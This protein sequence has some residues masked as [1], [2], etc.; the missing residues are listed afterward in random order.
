MGIPM[1]CIENVLPF[2]IGLSLSGPQPIRP[3][4]LNPIS[5]IK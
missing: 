1:Y 4:K 3:E 5:N 2:E